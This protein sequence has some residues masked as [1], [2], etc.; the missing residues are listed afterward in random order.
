MIPVIVI[1][2]ESKNLPTM[3]IFILIKFKCVVSMV[4]VLVAAARHK[5]F[6]IK[7]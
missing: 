1:E 7:S 3:A 2:N 6:I 4:L 5:S